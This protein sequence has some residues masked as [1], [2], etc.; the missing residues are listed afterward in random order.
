[1]LVNCMLTNWNMHK[2]LKNKNKNTLY[3]LKK[4]ERREMIV[5]ETQIYMKKGR[6][7]EKE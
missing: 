1:M 4:F 3:N 6:T 2:S 7:I 5:S